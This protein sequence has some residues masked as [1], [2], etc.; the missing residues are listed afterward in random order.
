LTTTTTVDRP[1]DR[2]N[3][4]DRLFA[5][6]PAI[7]LADHTRRY[8]PAPLAGFELIDEVALAGLR[9]RGGAG[10]PTHRKLAAVADRRRPVV[11]AN[12]CE[13]EPASGK[14]RSLLRFAPHLVLDGAMAAATAVGA[15]RVV[16]CIERGQPAVADAVR[17]ACRERLAAG[18]DHRPI[19]LCELPRRYVAGEETALVHW[20]NGG[21]A[22][23]QFVPPRPF[24]RGVDR[25]PTLI[26]NVETL[27]HLALIARFGAAWYRSVGTPEDPGSYLLT[28]TGAAGQPGVYEVAGGTPL[29]QVL[30][31]AGGDLDRTDAVLVGGYFGTWLPA[32]TA[33]GL[34]V[35]AASLASA[36]ASLGCGAVFALPRGA[37]GLAEATRVT[38]WLADQNAGQCGPCVH[39]LD[40][41]ATAM[42]R[43][44]AGRISGARSAVGLDAIAALTGLV[45]GRGACKHPDGVVR[46]VRSAVDTFGPHLREHERR[47]PCMAGP[48][49]LPTPA[50]GGWR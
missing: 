10:F 32:S 47:G 3:R 42:E 20:L 18:V 44:V 48:P 46:F 41:I 33:A 43:L 29:R 40:A 11:V 13:G 25:R 15:T 4:P 39:G 23:P 12:G 5:N 8:G 38:R 27:A 50:P 21:E 1:T 19:E 24:E 9:G 6:P 45:E 22:R 14:D 49:L 35:S 7:S 36:G 31:E 2:P 26:D 30:A 16:V 37:C 34:T 28:V 17:A